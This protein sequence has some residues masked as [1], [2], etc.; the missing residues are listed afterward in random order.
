MQ[1]SYKGIPE[2]VTIHDHPFSKATLV[3]MTDGSEQ[4]IEQYVTTDGQTLLQF[5]LISPTEE[6]LKDLQPTIQSLKFKTDDSA[7]STKRTKKP[8]VGWKLGVRSTPCL[9]PLPN[10][11][12]PDLCGE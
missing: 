12:P 7:K 2:R 5:I 3:Q 9:G 6:G 10:R 8:V 11:N 1:V 4:H